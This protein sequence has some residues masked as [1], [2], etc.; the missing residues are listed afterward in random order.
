METNYNKR[1]TYALLISICVACFLVAF[2]S[3]RMT[4]IESRLSAIETDYYDG[5]QSADTISE[6]GIDPPSWNYDSEIT[7]PHQNRIYDIL[8][9]ID[10]LTDTTKELISQAWSRKSSNLILQ[11]NTLFDEGSLID[12]SLKLSDGTYITATIQW[13][14]NV[15]GWELTRWD[16]VMPNN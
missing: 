15:N 11:V 6:D 4:A 7:M 5:V 16:R 3:D 2:N 14:S 8:M 12:L 1:I 13:H 9:G 10:G